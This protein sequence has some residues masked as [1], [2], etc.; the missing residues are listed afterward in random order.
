MERRLAAIL[1]ADVVGYGRLMG[2]DEAGTLAA[3]KAD[4]N[5]LIDPKAAQ[6]HGRTIKLMGDGA[7]MEFASVVDAVTFSVEVQIAMRERNA[8]VSEDRRIVYRIGINIGDII[9]EG[10]DIFGD[11]VNVAARLEGL[12]ESGGICMERNVFNQVKN[13]LDLGFEHL[14]E[15]EVKNIAEPVTVYRVVLDDKAAA[16]VTSVV[17]EATKPVNRRWMV[18]VA[19]VL[20]AAVGGMLWWQ[21]WAPDVEP[22]SVERMAFPL[23]EGPSIAVL[24]FT[25]M[26]ADPEQE[27][28]AEGMTEDLITD[29]AKISALF[30]IDRISA[31]SYKDK[32]VNVQQV[33]E[34][35]GVRFV[36]E[37][38]V[39]K[40]G[41]QVRVTAQLVDAI[42]GYHLWSER[43]DRRL[44]ALFEVRDDITQNI[45]DALEIT[46]TER[47]V[48]RAR[49]AA[50]T[51]VKAWELTRRGTRVFRRNTK[52]DNVRARAMAEEA[53]KL[54]PNYVVAWN[55]LAYTHYYDARTGWSEDSAK[56]LAR[57][58]E[59]TEKILALDPQHPDNYHL[60]LQIHLL[61][62]EQE[63]A[64]AVGEEGVALYPNHSINIALLA[65]ALLLSGRPEEALALMHKAMRLSPHYP[66]YFLNIV[67]HA[68]HEMGHYEDAVAALQ[69]SLERNPNS[70][71]T[72]TGIA[73][74]YSD[75]GRESEAQ[76]AA[77]EILRINPKFSVRTWAK[78]WPFKDDA[79]L[80]KRLDALRKAGLP[81]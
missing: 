66:Y 62:G 2:A 44:T 32:A 10:D 59:I 72:W 34:E 79:V 17:H 31:F 1:A 53:I 16:L 42:T 63:K 81:E 74:V 47:E 43:Y 14:G 80:E 61:K 6:Y 71:Y 24:P 20:V 5:E 54:D 35:L 67:G 39:Q 57:T 76:K 58:E 9:V 38:S 8:E 21:P 37:G 50:T 41:N 25:N 75:A 15:R 29:L 45:V 73:A 68:H 40:E 46:L 52:A 60:L 70:I 51:N 49:R 19:V 12:A 26:S 30:V 3:L 65:Q 77:A 69:R 64:I 23:P 55:L 48:T 27:Y 33:A 13:K 18:A 78:A 4:R 56:S 28:F 36:L 11:G 22:A 7:L